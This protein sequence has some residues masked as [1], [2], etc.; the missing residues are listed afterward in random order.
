MGK[1]RFFKNFIKT[2]HKKIVFNRYTLLRS[3]FVNKISREQIEK[4]IYKKKINLVFSEFD[5]Q[6]F[7]SNLSSL[8]FKGISLKMFKFFFLDSKPIVAKIKNLLKKKDFNFF[9]DTLSLDKKKKLIQNFKNKNLHQVFPL[10]G[11]E[12]D[13]SKRVGL[14]FLK[15]KSFFKNRLRSG[16]F[17][18]SA[19]KLNLIK[20]DPFLFKTSRKNK[21]LNKNSFINSNFSILSLS[22]SYNFLS[23]LEN[24][25]L[26]KYKRYSLIFQK[27]SLK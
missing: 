8:N 4:R 22:Y 9:W 20:K 6:Y 14:K 18:V 2:S 15:K 7:Y 5:F 1:Q 25:N 19:K 17:Q 21:T 13:I 11:L 26:N 27:K 12:K 10:I 23:C 3:S 16:L 24:T